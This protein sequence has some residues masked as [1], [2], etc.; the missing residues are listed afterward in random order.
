MILKDQLRALHERET[1]VKVQGEKAKAHAEGLPT[2]ELAE[3]YD[4]ARYW[5]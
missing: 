4:R 5:G 2:R 1:P 3:L